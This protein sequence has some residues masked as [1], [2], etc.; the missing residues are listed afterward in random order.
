[1]AINLSNFLIS[2]EDSS[3]MADFQDLDHLDGLSIS[4][5]S[6]NL[7]NNNRDDLVL[8]YF[9]N[10]AEYASVYT[11]SKVVS[12]NIKW[13]KSV[14]PKKIKALIVNA[15]NANCLTGS[16]GYNSL[17]EI[18]EETAKLLTDKQKTDEDDP[19]KVKSGEIIFGCTG[20]I[21]EPFPTNKIKSS[22]KN[23][24]DKIKYTQNKYLWIKAAMSILTTD[25]KP[26]LAME[27][28]KIGK[29]K[30]K[31]YGIA[32]GSGMIYPNM[33]TTLAY[34]FTDANLSSVVLKKI[35]KKNINNT[36]NAI[37]CDGDTSTNDMITI[38]STGS[39]KNKLITNVNDSKLKEFDK[40]VNN[41]LLNLAKRV[42][43]DGEG[44][45]KFIQIDILKCKSE[46]DARKLAF[47]IANSALV[48][49]AIAG[50]DPNW[51]RIMMAVGKNDVDLNINLINL[52]IGNNRVLDKGQL[53]KNYSEENLKKYM[54]SD[55]INIIL[56]INL[57]RK[58]FTCYTMD[59]TKKYLEINSDYRT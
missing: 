48:K 16:K 33:G 54:K 37:S 35:L 10:G 32:K 5:T 41:I 40:C 52:M 49:T 8:F 59:L 28:C 2:K 15:R 4:V 55:T 3:K 7:Y 22:I 19:K 36:F 18:A 50:E 14:K 44:A 11:Q 51:G 46:D 20:T 30:I 9:R 39:A 25:L 47:S 31:I 21:G 53:S 57:G 56:E 23:L 13:N 34:I 58:N 1:M 43:S 27:E 17:K 6:A 12:E 45:S 24:V 29:T 42:V 38:F 26:K